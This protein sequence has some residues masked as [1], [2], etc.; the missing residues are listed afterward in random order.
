MDPVH[1]R[2]P[3]QT[4]PSIQGGPKNQLFHW[5]QKWV[6]TPFF[7]GMPRVVMLTLRF[8]GLVISPQFITIDLEVHLLRPV[9]PNSNAWVS[10]HSLPECSSPVNDKNVVNENNDVTSR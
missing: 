2:I 10:P 7:N 1:Q 6:P 4:N 3:F 8:Y 9:A 5:R